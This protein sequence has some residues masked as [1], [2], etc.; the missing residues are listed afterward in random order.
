M[1]ENY[2]KK[3]SKKYRD[4]MNRPTPVTAP[5]SKVRKPGVGTRHSRVEWRPSR[6]HRCS[7]QPRRGYG[8][9][10]ASS[11]WN[12]GSIRWSAAEWGCRRRW[13]WRYLRWRRGRRRHW[14]GCHQ[15]S[16]GGSSRRA[17]EKTAARRRRPRRSRPS[18]ARRISGGRCVCVLRSPSRDVEITT[19]CP[20]W[21]CRW[22]S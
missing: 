22:K 4:E 11:E 16:G 12:L 13:R 18:Y 6:S 19:F 21:F 14:P 8:A 3:Q 9:E 10:S 7:S 15:G 2:I 17:A 20:C 1:R 5:S